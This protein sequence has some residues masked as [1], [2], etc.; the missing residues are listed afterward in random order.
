MNV[1][2]EIPDEFAGVLATNGQDTARR[3]LEDS[4][5]Q[6]YREGKI[7]SR[8]VREALGMASRFEVD[9]FLLKYQI[10]DYTVEDLKKDIADTT[11]FNYLVQMGQVEVM[12]VLYDEVYIPT[13]VQSEL[14]APG[15]P[16]EVRLW[17][18][19]LP[20]WIKVS[21]DSKTDDP[22]LLELDAG[23]CAA[24]ALALRLNAGL[25][26]LDERLGRAV[27]TRKGIPVSG[28]LGVLRDAA[29]HGLLDFEAAVFELRSLGF[30]IANE[31]IDEA[32]RD[33]LR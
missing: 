10:Y 13:E 6:A 20:P 28:T 12:R 4:V 14:T 23:E 26:L 9:P 2:V 30:R 21:S 27:A 32:R 25:L 15:T 29:R 22:D 3:L 11:P 17:A 16:V 33:I 19:Q 5:A 7:G 8:G 1:T 31:V 18:Q 24:I